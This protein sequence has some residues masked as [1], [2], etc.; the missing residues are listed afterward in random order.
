M[1]ASERLRLGGEII[2]SGLVLYPPGKSD[3]GSDIAGERDRAGEHHFTS[4]RAVAGRETKHQLENTTHNST[5]VT[6]AH[7]CASYQV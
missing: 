6:S 1:W 7:K 2:E 3:L 4:V 5:N